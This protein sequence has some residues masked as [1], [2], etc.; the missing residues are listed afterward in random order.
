MVSGTRLF[1]KDMFKEEECGPFAADLI[2]WGAGF[3]MH[4]IPKW[5]M[6]GPAIDTLKKV[7]KKIINTEFHRSECLV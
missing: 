5:Y 4:V 6:E 1:F 3:L 7:Q 2:Y